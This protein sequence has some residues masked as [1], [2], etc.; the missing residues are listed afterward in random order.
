MKQLTPG[1]LAQLVNSRQPIGSRQGRAPPPPPPLAQIGSSLSVESSL[2]ELQFEG[3]GTCRDSLLATGRTIEAPMTRRPPPHTNEWIMSLGKLISLAP[4]P[5][6]CLNV[7]RANERA[8]VFSFYLSR[9]PFYV[10]FYLFIYFYLQAEGCQREGNFCR[11]AEKWPRLRAE[12][13]KS[14]RPRVVVVSF[15][16]GNSICFL[17]FHRFHRSEGLARNKLAI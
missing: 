4:L 9:C 2:V 12:P 15:E 1:R 16:G 6:V 11:E 7:L 14:G 10:V 8:P 5:V 17:S 13:V 3:P